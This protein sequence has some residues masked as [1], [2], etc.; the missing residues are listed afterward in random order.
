M[1]EPFKNFWQPLNYLFT[2]DNAEIR[3]Q[4]GEVTHD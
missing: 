3:P 2:G 1:A 4:T